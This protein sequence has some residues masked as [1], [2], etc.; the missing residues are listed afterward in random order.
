MWFLR[1]CYGINL[2]ILSSIESFGVAYL[3]P[4]IPFEEKYKKGLL[5]PPIWKREKRPGFL[6]TKKENKQ[7]NISMEWK[8]IK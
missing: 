3:S 7:S 8:Y 5:V 4:Y 6:D 1:H 2:F